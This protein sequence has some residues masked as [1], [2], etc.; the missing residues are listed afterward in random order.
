MRICIFGNTGFLGSEVVKKLG[1]NF[2]LILPSRKIEKDYNYG[3]KVFTPFNIEKNI[4]TFK[5]DIILNLIGILKETSG[6]TY[7]KAH[8]FNTKEI[9]SASL[10][11]G[12]KKIIYISAYGV[13]KGCKSRY[14]KT[15]EESE[16]MIKSSGLD[17]LIIRPS[18]ILGEGQMLLKE[19]KKIASF[20]P[21]VPSPSGN[22]APVEVSVVINDIIEGINGKSGI[23]ELKG[24]VITYR[25]MF[26]I[27]LESLGIKR[28][29]I[30]VPNAFFYPLVLTQIFMKNPVMTVDLYRM[31]T[32]SKIYD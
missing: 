23:S 7:E 11:Y 6:I 18:V 12:V 20:V 22:V 8:V 26:E 28:K 1:D 9:V 4:K 27:M 14:F 32:C 24:K 10:N 17:Y 19:L 16:N 31:L 3:N 5:P 13:F 21:F 2:E 30:S 25:E 15:K 29:V